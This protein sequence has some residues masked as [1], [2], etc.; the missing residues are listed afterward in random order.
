MLKKDEEKVRRYRLR[1]GNRSG[2]KT[3]IT[4]QPSGNINYK[5]EKPR[6]TEEELWTDTCR[7]ARQCEEMTFNYEMT[8][9]DEIERMRARW[10]PTK[11]CTKRT[12]CYNVMG[13]VEKSLETIGANIEEE[14]KERT[15]IKAKRASTEETDER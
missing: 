5:H 12:K 14:K 6:S 11:W 15:G 2:H 1:L 7:L 9:L 4:R 3:E 13:R 8:P 10:G